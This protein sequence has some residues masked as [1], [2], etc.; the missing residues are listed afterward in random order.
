MNQETQKCPLT[1]RACNIPK[2]FHI[3]ETVDGQGRIINLCQKCANH[4][5]IEEAVHLKPNLA[6]VTQQ[7]DEVAPAA[8]PNCG[9]TVESIQSA[10]RLGCLHCYQHFGSKS[11]QFLDKGPPVTLPEDKTE[12]QIEELTIA[13]KQSLSVY[14]N[15]LHSTL[16]AVLKVEKYEDAARIRDQIK[17]AE[18]IRS[19]KEM[20]EKEIDV[21]VE[22]GQFDKAK[23]IKNS[24]I[25]LIGNF[26]E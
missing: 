20:L 2:L 12:S 3:S 8:C 17:E 5:F 14:L 22:A 10:G 21:A 24:V 19:Q 16:S 11:L 13:K 6:V 23:Q 7:L 15:K 1:G 18:K 9:A 25:S 26:L 4:H